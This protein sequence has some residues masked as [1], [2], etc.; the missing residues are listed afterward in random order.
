MEEV[1]EAEEVEEVGDEDSVA[2]ES[3]FARKLASF[4]MMAGGYYTPRRIQSEARSNQ[5]FLNFFHMVLDFNSLCFH[6][7]VTQQSYSWPSFLRRDS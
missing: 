6:T 3:R 7:T 2:A 1:K 5:I 4:G